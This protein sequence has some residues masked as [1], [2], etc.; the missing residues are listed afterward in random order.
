MNAERGFDHGMFVPLKLMFENADIPCVQLSLLASL[1]PESHILL[2]E[3]IREVR[4]RG[5]LVLG[6]GMSYHNLK[7]FFKRDE[8]TQEQSEVF[9]RWLTAVC[10]DQSTDYQEKKRQLIRWTDAPAARECHPREEH[11][12][13]LH[14]CFGAAGQDNPAETVFNEDLMGEAGECIPLELDEIINAQRQAD[15]NNYKS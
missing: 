4:K 12:L 3:A 2:G 13:P 6:S 1:D 11:L 10:T 7:A 15:G 5:V 8:K 9:D 14:V